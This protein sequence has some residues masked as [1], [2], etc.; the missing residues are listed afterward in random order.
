MLPEC[1]K[2]LSDLLD[3]VDQNVK[4]TAVDYLYALMIHDTCEARDRWAT[5]RVYI[6]AY[7]SWQRIKD[8]YLELDCALL[9]AMDYFYH[10]CGE[11]VTPEKVNLKNKVAEMLLVE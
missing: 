4:K 10:S 2:N 6:A 1:L 7:E 5:R 11:G 3:Q 8:P 9:L